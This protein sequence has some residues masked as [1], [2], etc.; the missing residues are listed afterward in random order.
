MV[1]ESFYWAAETSP[2]KTLNEEVARDSRTRAW[3]TEWI[4]EARRLLSELKSQIEEDH[5]VPRR[6]RAAQYIADTAIDFRDQ[7]LR[8]SVDWPEWYQDFAG[9]FQ[10]IADAARELA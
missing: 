6:G 9:D 1:L 10:E 5:P 7:V 4:S 3:I 8:F 2:R